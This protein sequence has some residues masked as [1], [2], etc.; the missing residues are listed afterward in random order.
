MIFL[1]S[2]LTVAKKFGQEVTETLRFEIARDARG[3][4][5]VPLVSIFFE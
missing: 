2:L 5:M 3:E 4:E 1:Q